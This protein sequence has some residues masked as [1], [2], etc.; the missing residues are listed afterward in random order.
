MTVS[1][2]TFCPKVGFFFLLAVAMP[3]EE[4]CHPNS[5]TLKQK[6]VSSKQRGRV[7]VLVRCG[8]VE[9]PWCSPASKTNWKE[10]CKD[11]KCVLA[12]LTFLDFSWSSSKSVLCVCVCVDSL[13]YLLFPVGS[14]PFRKLLCHHGNCRLPIKAFSCQRGA[15]AVLDPQTWQPDA[16]NQ[17]S[18][19]LYSSLN[20]PLLSCQGSTWNSLWLNKD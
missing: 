15:I 19:L 13:L 1:V 8:Q 11:F 4:N 16:A 5:G 18:P 12:L 6:A 9:Q 2:P 3:Q 20:P 14:G 17:T 10:S 7:M